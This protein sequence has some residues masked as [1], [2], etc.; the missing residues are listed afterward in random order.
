MTRNMLVHL[1]YQMDLYTRLGLGIDDRGGLMPRAQLFVDWGPRGTS[2]SCDVSGGESAHAYCRDCDGGT[3]R[4]DVYLPLTCTGAGDTA[5]QRLDLYGSPHAFCDFSYGMCDWGPK[6]WAY[7]TDGCWNAI[8]GSPEGSCDLAMAEDLLPS[9][10]RY[11]PD[12][13]S[14]LHV[15]PLFFVCERAEGCAD[16]TPFLERLSWSDTYPLQMTTHEGMHHATPGPAVAGHIDGGTLAAFLSEGFP[17]LAPRMVYPLLASWANRDNLVP[18]NMQAQYL[19]DPV[20]GGRVVPSCYASGDQDPVDSYYCPT[21]DRFGDLTPTC[22]LRACTFLAEGYLAL[23]CCGPGSPGGCPPGIPAPLDMV[24]KNGRPYRIADWHW[25]SEWF[26]AAMIRYSAMV[27]RAKGMRDIL[28]LLRSGI[29]G[30][31]DL[32]LPADVDQTTTVSTGMDSLYYKLHTGAHYLMP[33]KESNAEAW[34]AFAANV[35]GSVAPEPIDRESGLDH[36]GVFVPTKHQSWRLGELRAEGRIDGP[37]DSDAWNAYLFAGR[38]YRIVVDTSSAA[39][40]GVYVRYDDR[41][42]GRRLE[43]FSPL[44]GLLDPKCAWPI[45]PTAPPSAGGAPSS[46]CRLLSGPAYAGVTIPGAADDLWFYSEQGLILGI[47]TAGSV[48]VALHPPTYRDAK[49]DVMPGTTVQPL[50]EHSAAWPHQIAL[51]APVAGWYRATVTPVDDRPTS[52]QL[53]FFQSQYQECD[54]PTILESTGGP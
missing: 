10:C 53:R 12:R 5:C 18:V 39:D 33:G 42:D 6:I 20:A 23:G 19:G 51:V 50:F 25:N 49:T 40:L 43:P 54:F 27:G 34:P 45:P 36:H 41:I 31:V 22:E 3:C 7:H 30:A 4:S 8:T 15:D 37:Y 28:G 44:D 46:G 48:K 35:G 26:L 29:R 47:T 16:G 2:F 17:E 13:G 38:A 32:S 52:Y 24:C 21:R 1:N 9:A 11:F 14:C